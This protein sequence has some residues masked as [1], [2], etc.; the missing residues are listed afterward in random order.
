MLV[1]CSHVL[2]AGS[3]VLMV[4]RCIG[5][6]GAMGYYGEAIWFGGAMDCD[7]RTTEFDGRVINFNE[8]H[9]T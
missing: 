3:K 9:R 8:G 7:C 2:M 4:G 6:G 5:Y 1:T